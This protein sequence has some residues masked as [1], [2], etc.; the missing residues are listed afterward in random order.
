M[1]K[2]HLG[3]NEVEGFI[4]VGDFVESHFSAVWAGE[5]LSRDHFQ[6][7]HEFESGAEIGV[8]EVD[9]RARLAQVRVAPGGES[10]R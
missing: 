7:Q 6:E 4:D 9:L 8:D 5:A 1:R 10:L 3:L 2:N